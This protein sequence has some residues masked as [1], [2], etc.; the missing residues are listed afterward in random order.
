MLLNELF[1]QDEL[2]EIDRRG[3]L[4]ALGAGA[5][6]A[7]TASIAPRAQADV[8]FGGFTQHD[9]GSQ[10]YQQGPMSLRQNPNGSQEA[11]YKFA[12][13]IIR[14]FKRGNVSGFSASGPNKDAIIN[15]VQTAKNRGI[16]VNSPRF[17]KYLETLLRQ[18]QSELE[19]GWREKTAAAMAAATLAYGGMHN[20]TRQQSAEPAVATAQQ[21]QVSPRASADP[22]FQDRIPLRDSLVDHAKRAG[23][24]GQ[25]L[26]HFVSQ[27]AHETGNWQ[28]MEEQPPQG[29]RNPQRYFARKY[30]GRKILGN[31]KKG[32]GYRYRGRG[33][34]QLT[35]R[36]NYTRAGRALGI[37][38]AN[39]PELAAQP[40][41]AAK[42]AVWFWKNRVA[43]RVQ[44]FDQAQV[45]DVTH[46]INPGQRG[47][48]QRAAHFQRVSQPR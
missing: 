1:V 11:E 42:I 22:V 45:R 40:D 34:V 3:F 2:D 20:L 5:A 19:E 36:D 16:D 6:T 33:Y 47:A 17:K 10:T 21:T 41:V 37:D 7:A 14:A 44:D 30:E 12:D 27:M 46:G 15:V 18:H 39:R 23:I 48:A 9:D 25:E 24:R 29:A 4:K 8:S 43:P 31:V 35:G 13:D 28:H 32:D 38:L 26:A